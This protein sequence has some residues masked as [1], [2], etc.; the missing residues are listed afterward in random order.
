M[1]LF[2]IIRFRVDPARDPRQPDQLLPDPR[3]FGCRHFQ[4]SAPLDPN[5]IAVE[6]EHPFREDIRTPGA[7]DARHRDF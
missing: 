7:V 3:R 4:V 1:V 2:P 5:Q 6:T